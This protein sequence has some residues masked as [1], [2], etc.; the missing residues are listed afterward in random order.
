MELEPEVG[1]TGGG[2]SLG[3]YLELPLFALG[4]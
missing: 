1:A 4:I 2:V 3:E